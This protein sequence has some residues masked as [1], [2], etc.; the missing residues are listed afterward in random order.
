MTCLGTSCGAT[1]SDVSTFRAKLAWVPTH[2][3]YAASSDA[4]LVNGKLK[5]VVVFMV[6]V[7]SVES[8]SNATFVST[9]VVFV[10]SA[11][12]A[13]VASQDFLDNLCRH[14]RENARSFT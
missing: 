12:D 9:I 8:P 14:Y 10:S 11:I 2:A 5:G 7:I 4:G 6:R 1:Y 13:V 3:S